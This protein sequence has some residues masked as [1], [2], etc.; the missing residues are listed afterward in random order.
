MPAAANLRRTYPY[1]PNTQS[2]LQVHMF[3]DKLIY[4]VTEKRYLLTPK[5]RGLPEKLTGPQL[6]RKVPSFYG[7]RRNIHFYITADIVHHSN[8]QG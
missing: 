1:V 7:T 3:T 6:L 5:S 8:I 4:N 2:V